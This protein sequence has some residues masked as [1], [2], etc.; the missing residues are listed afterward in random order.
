MGD[1]TAK[2]RLNHGGGWRSE[3]EWPPARTKYATYYFR[4]GGEL[5]TEMPGENDSPAR[6]QHDPDNPVPTIAANV[7]GFYEQVALGDGM[8]PQYTPPRA[9][10]RSII[11]DGAAHQ[12]EEPGIV[13]AKPP[14]LPLAARPDVL[15]FQTSPVR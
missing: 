7:T 9:R 12:K 14:Y 5:D 6:F 8:A 10:M 4:T 1:A 13:G 11:M 15:V 3:K 2:G